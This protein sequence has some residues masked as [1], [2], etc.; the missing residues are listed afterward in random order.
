[1]SFG[2]S[3]PK[4]LED[5]LADPLGTVE[6]TIRSY[7]DR[8]LPAE[9]GMLKNLRHLSISN[10]QLVEL[11]VEICSLISLQTLSV[12][13]KLNDLPECFSDLQNLRL[14]NLSENDF[15]TIPIAV[16]ELQNLL[17]LSFENNGI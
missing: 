5:A 13:G 2:P 16:Y 7:N 17:E 10:S 1:M 11:P 6:L 15:A 12:R 14:L 4:S 9:I 8:E 3:S